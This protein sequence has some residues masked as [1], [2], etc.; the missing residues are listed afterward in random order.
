MRTPHLAAATPHIPVQNAARTEGEWR[1]YHADTWYYEVFDL[2]RKLVLTG[3]MV[4]S[5]RRHPT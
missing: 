3:L 4:R 2:A 1:R 5:R